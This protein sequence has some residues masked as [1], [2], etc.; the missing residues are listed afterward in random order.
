MKLQMDIYIAQQSFF[1]EKRTSI[2][3]FF[4]SSEI[5]EDIYMLQQIFFLVQGNQW[6]NSS[7]LD[8]KHLLH[9]DSDHRSYVLVQGMH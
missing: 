4:R 7:F 6:Y 3:K 1:L 9:N 2:H 5:Q 8:S